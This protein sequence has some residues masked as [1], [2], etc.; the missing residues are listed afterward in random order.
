ML[1]LTK[2]KETVLH[3]FPLLEMRVYIT[4]YTFFRWKCEYISRKYIMFI[5]NTISLL[6]Q[7]I[8]RGPNLIYFNHES[9]DR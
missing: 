6:G 3:L 8:R 9:L 4:V 1:I 5:I 7:F 2:Q